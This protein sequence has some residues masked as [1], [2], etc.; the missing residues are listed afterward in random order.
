M[1]HTKSDFL[2]QRPP[3]VQ[4]IVLKR[5]FYTHFLNTLDKIT[6]EKYTCIHTVSVA[7]VQPLQM[8]DLFLKHG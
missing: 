6:P 4:G 7:S 8:L 5:L 1:L 2:T 3:L